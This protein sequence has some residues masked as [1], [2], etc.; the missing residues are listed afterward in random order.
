M[1][2]MEKLT[3]NGKLLRSGYSLLRRTG[4]G[5]RMAADT[6]YKAGYF[7]AKHPEIELAKN[8]LQRNYKAGLITITGLVIGI[9][10]AIMILS[11]K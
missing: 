3:K 8:H 2:T 5:I 9:L 1:R 10:G 11:K 4:R 7:M 6:G